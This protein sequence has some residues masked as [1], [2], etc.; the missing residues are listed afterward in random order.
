MKRT[1]WIQR[2][3]APWHH[4][5]KPSLQLSIYITSILLYNDKVS[6][7]FNIIAR[8]SSSGVGDTVAPEAFCWLGR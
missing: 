6:A 2:A 5:I 8:Y 7:A 1:K 3:S 4:L